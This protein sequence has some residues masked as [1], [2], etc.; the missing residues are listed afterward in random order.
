[1][2]ASAPIKYKKSPIATINLIET[3]IK[4][5][6]LPLIETTN[7]LSDILQPS[8]EISNDAPVCNHNRANYCPILK[9]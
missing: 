9:I 5:N 1:M 7:S 6:L 3:G 4:E 2:A 8:I